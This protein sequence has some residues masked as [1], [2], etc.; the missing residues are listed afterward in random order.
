MRV[1]GGPTAHSEAAPQAF[2]QLPPGQD[3]AP[4]QAPLRPAQEDKAGP[5]AHRPVQ[6]TSDHPPAHAKPPAAQQKQ[7]P[8]DKKAEPHDEHEP[9]KN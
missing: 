5:N 3:R 6:P 1:H 2:I 8:E 7:K 4:P 9:Q